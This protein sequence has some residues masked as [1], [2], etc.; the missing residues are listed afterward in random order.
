MANQVAI[1]SSVIASVF[2]RDGEARRYY[3]H[4]PQHERA[5]TSTNEPSSRV[6]MELKRDLAVC[7]TLL[8]EGS[9]SEGDCCDAEGP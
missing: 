3:A 9:N 4:L 1:T 5:L 6:H 2:T 8:L 7:R